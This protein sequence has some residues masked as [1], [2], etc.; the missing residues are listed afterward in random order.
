[1]NRQLSRLASDASLKVLIPIFGLMGGLLAGWLRTWVRGTSEI[2]SIALVIS[3]GLV[4]SAIGM[5]AVLALAYPVLTTRLSST[6]S[7]MALVLVAALTIW[8]VLSILRDL[9]TNGIN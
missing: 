8:F 6:K 1:M 7:L 5:G 2:T 9:M 4:G 3:G